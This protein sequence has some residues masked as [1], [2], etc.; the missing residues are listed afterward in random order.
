LLIDGGLNVALHNS[1]LS[2]ELGCAVGTA[3]RLCERSS[4]S[5]DISELSKHNGGA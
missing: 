3:T 1:F 4:A 2:G 5:H